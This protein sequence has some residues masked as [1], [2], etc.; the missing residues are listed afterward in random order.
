[1][2]ELV[3]DL[4]DRLAIDQE[5]FVFGEMIVGQEGYPGPEGSGQKAV[6]RELPSKAPEIVYSAFYGSTDLFPDGI[7]H[8]GL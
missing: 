3:P 7:L 2:R 5:V 8:L 6:D 1:M 4:A